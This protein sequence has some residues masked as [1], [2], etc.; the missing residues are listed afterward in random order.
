MTY[1]HI[2]LR[3]QQRFTW[4]MKKM[5][6]KIHNFKTSDSNYIQFDR[7]SHSTHVFFHF[8][9]VFLRCLNYFNVIKMIFTK[10]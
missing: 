9:K 3:I 4:L 10:F 1:F 5:Q 6:R 2:F 7:M 8:L